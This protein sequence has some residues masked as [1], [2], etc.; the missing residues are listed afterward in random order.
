MAKEH[1]YPN[2]AHSPGSNKVQGAKKD[3]SEC[4][5]ERDGFDGEERVESQI[6]ELDLIEESQR[7]I[8]T[9]TSA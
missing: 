1:S 3:S 9:L 2:Q 8:T 4:V 6:A 5:H 7:H